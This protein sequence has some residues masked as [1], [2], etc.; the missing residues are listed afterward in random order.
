SGSRFDKF[1]AADSA[2]EGFFDLAGLEIPDGADSAQ[3]QISVEAMDPLLQGS[4]ASGP[5]KQGQVKPSGAAAPVVLTIS[6]GG[7]VA[8]DLPMTGSASK[9]GDRFDRGTF[10]DPSRLPPNGDWAGLL[11]GY[12]ETDYFAFTGRADRTMSIDVAALDEGDVATEDKAQPVIGVWTAADAE[13]SPP[14][15]SVTYFN[16]DQVGLTRIRPDIF[17]STDFKIGIADYR[18]DGRPDFRYRA[19]VFYG[20]TVSPDRADVRGGIFTIHGTGFRSG[21]T[22]TVGDSSATV[23]AVNA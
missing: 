18:G 23:L 22:V 11:S 1:G 10:A 9:T 20:D 17:V 16:S 8:Q 13:G 5:Y 6:K 7:D 2:L 15:I 3:Y 21:T 19:H 14:Q 4:N 12:G